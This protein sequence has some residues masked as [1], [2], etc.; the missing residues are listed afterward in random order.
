MEPIS[1]NECQRAITECFATFV[2]IPRF[3]Y[4]PCSIEL[5]SFFGIFWS[6]SNV[7]LVY[8]FDACV[9]H[10]LLLYSDTRRRWMY[11]ELLP[12]YSVYL[13]KDQIKRKIKSKTEMI[14][15]DCLAYITSPCISTS[16][17]EVSWTIEC[18]EQRRWQS[19]ISFDNCLKFQMVTVPDANISPSIILQLLRMLMIKLQ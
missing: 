19:Q 8:Y 4:K 13:P 10:D 12:V 15:Y 5:A 11:I 14:W 1:R 3:V 9:L 17:P 18:N 6:L 2:S 7:S 16:V